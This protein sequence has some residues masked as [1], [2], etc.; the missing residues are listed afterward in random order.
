MSLPPAE[1]IP[2][3]SAL[4]GKSFVSKRG[5]DQFSNVWDVGD[6]ITAIDHSTGESAFLCGSIIAQIATF[7]NVYDEVWALLY[8]VRVSIA[9]RYRINGA[10]QIGAQ[11][12]SYDTESF[13]LLCLSRV[14]EDIHICAVCS[15]RTDD[16]TTLHL[17]LCG[18]LPF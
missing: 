4:R 6:Y 15:F 9:N 12:V 8:P 16:G 2:A 18:P 17:P 7:L 13:R 3:L 14:P 5:T 1:S 10:Y 11:D